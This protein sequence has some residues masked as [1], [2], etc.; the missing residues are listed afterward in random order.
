MSEERGK[1]QETEGRVETSF[2]QYSYVVTHVQAVAKEV[3][4]SF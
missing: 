2:P 1:S 3:Q 4:K